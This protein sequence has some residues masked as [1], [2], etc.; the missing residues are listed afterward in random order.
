MAPSYPTARTFYGRSL[1]I[2][3]QLDYREGIAILLNLT[4]LV[5]ERCEMATA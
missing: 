5:A 3:R 1:A 2:R 4:A